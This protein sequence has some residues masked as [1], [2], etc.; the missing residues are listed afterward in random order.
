MLYVQFFQKSAISDNLVEA[1]GTRAVVILDARHTQHRNAVIA[2]EQ[3]KHRGYLAW[4][5]NRGESF[6]RATPFGIVNRI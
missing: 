1:C 5:F 6:T 4:Q 3:C 2:G